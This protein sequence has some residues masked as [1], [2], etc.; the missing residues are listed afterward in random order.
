V[1]DCLEN[2]PFIDAVATRFLNY[3]NQTLQFQSTLA[4]LKDPPADYQQA[5]VDVLQELQ[6]LKD[7]VAAGASTSQYMFEVEL[8]LLINRIHDAHVYLSAGVLSAFSFLSP[9]GLVSASTDGTAAPLVYLQCKKC[10]TFYV[11]GHLTIL[12]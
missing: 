11:S 7:N 2:V 12:R 3:Y 5:P 4:F 6:R 1:F 8:Q 10:C 9:L